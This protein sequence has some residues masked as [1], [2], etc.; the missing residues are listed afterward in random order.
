M[1][2]KYSL[3]LPASKWAKVIRGTAIAG[4]GAILTYLGSH[5]ADIDFGIYTPAIVASLSILINYLRQT[6]VEMEA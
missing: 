6:I 5:L 2:K 1:K 3:A 4:G